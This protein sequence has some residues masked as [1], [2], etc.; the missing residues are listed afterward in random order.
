L[1]GW[2]KERLTS[3]VEVTQL[4]L[5]NSFV[6]TVDDADD[7]AVLVAELL[8]DVETL[9]LAD[10]EMLELAVDE[11]EEVAEVVAVDDC[12]VLGEVISQSK[13]RLRTMALI[14]EFS[15][16]AVSAQVL[17]GFP[18]NPLGEHCSSPTLPGNCVCS[19][20]I[21]FRYAAVLV[22]LSL[23]I[24]APEE[25]PRVTPWQERSVYVEGEILVAQSRI[26]R[27]NGASWVV[28]STIL[29]AIK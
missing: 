10:V 18:R 4:Y 1:V 29:G 2:R 6:V 28:Q 12:D 23:M 3:A 15:W 22:Q 21:A 9:V 5:P 24:A 27:F 16:S 25:E 20:M 13:K 17:V 19:A 14:N 26:A 11:A 7:V 8:T